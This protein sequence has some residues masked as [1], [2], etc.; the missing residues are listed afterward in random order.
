M[1]SVRVILEALC[2]LL[3]EKGIIR[4]EKPKEGFAFIVH[5]RGTHDAVRQYPF[6]KFLS[7]RVIEFWAR[8]YWPFIGSR[9]TGL[10]N[11]AGEDIP[12]WIIICPLMARQI[13]ED[14]KLATKMILR[15]VRLAENMGAKMVGLGALL[16]SV[17]N[18]GQ[19]LLS[20][21]SISL[22]TGRTMTALTVFQFTLQALEL[23]EERIENITVAIVGAAGSVGGATALLLEKAGAKNFILIDIERKS[24]RVEKLMRD[25]NSSGHLNIRKSHR[26]GDIKDA[27][28]IVTATN[29]PEALVLSDDVKPGA[30]VVDDAQP[31]DVHPD[32]MKRDDVL[33]LSAGVLHTPGILSH[34]N[35]SLAK[36]D[37]NFSCLGEVLLL[38]KEGLYE[39]H[40]AIGA[41]EYSQIGLLKNLAEREGFVPGTFQNG[42]KIYTADDINRVKAI[43]KERIL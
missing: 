24:E 5:P 21:T 32:V 31:S 29:T 2:D 34:F 37:E 41:F 30:I 3:I 6:A 8:H 26:I 19:E 14:R 11:K 13:L 10:K 18:G 16:A 12:G 35:F 17:T 9:I 4:P 33:V 42:Y 7:P 25:I 23:L 39:N 43:R 1:R 38:M 20:R 36:R 22:T 28:V 15:S 27:D 40:F